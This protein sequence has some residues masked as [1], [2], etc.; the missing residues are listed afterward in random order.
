[1]F[2]E[3]DIEI[4]VEKMRQDDGQKVNQDTIVCENIEDHYNVCYD[5]VFNIKERTDDNLVKG[6]DNLYTVDPFLTNEIK[7]FEWLKED[8]I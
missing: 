6:G 7:L 8:D 5:Y 4:S 2:D 3:W 1:M